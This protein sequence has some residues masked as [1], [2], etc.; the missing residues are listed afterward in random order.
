VGNFQAQTGEFLKG[1]GVVDAI[2]HELF[3]LMV[4]DQTRGRGPFQDLVVHLFVD[5]R[6]VLIVMARLVSQDLNS[7]AL[8]VFVNTLEDIHAKLSREAKQM[9]LGVCVVLGV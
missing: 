9:I 6:Q 5:Q 7:T 1:M 8:D 3:E 2:G 4:R